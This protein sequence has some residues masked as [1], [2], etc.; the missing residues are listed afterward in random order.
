M[1]PLIARLSTIVSVILRGLLLYTL[2]DPDTH[3]PE[4]HGNGMKYQRRNRL[5]KSGETFHVRGDR[6]DDINASAD[7]GQKQQTTQYI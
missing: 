3:H 5:R 4:E 6:H 7:A 1:H 2:P